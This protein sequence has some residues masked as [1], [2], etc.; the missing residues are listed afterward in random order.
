MFKGLLFHGF[1]LS[2]WCARCLTVGAVGRVV[3][4]G[5]G[6]LGLLRLSLCVLSGGHAAVP[7]ERPAVL[8]LNS[9]GLKL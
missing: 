7:A 5:C 6:I 1:V 8:N 3:F 2:V 4:C 9:N